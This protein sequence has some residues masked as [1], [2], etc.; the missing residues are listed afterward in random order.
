MAAG[1]AVFAVSVCLWLAGRLA[2]AGRPRVGGPALVVPLVVAWPAGGTGGGLAGRAG[3]GDVGLLGAGGRAARGRGAGRG[4]VLWRHRPAPSPVRSLASPAELA[5]IRGTGGRRSGG[6][7]A[8]VACADAPPTQMTRPDRG[9]ALGRAL[10]APA[11]GLRLVGGRHPG[12]LHA[13][14]REDHGGRGPGDPGRARRGRRHLEQGRPLQLTAELRARDTEQR[15]WVF[16]PQHIAHAEQTWW[17]NP[18][19]GT[20]SI[21]D[22]TRL[23][24]AFVLTVDAGARRSTSGRR[25]PAS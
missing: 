5:S 23:A 19:G 1:A 2:S 12:G 22:V 13:A 8:A 3:R 7:D 17:F 24:A 11:P 9:V 25:R 16:D 14:D 6:A 20:L 15:V 4:G 10:P 21:D 18:L